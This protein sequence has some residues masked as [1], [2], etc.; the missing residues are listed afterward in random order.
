GRPRDI[1][2]VGMDYVTDLDVV[3]KFDKEQLFRMELRALIADL[4]TPSGGGRYTFTRPVKRPNGTTANGWAR[5]S[6]WELI[7][8]LEKAPEE[9]TSELQ[10]RENLVCRLLLEKKNDDDSVEAS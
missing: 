9:H 6:E 1:R 5:L 10:S 3:A 7:Q 4:L 8:A 2:S